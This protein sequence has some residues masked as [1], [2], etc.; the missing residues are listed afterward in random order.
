MTRGMAAGQVVVKSA[1]DMF[2]H[3]VNTQV[4]V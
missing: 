3:C 1:K 4:R 2:D